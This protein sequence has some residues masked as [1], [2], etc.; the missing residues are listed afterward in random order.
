MPGCCITWFWTCSEGSDPLE[1]YA[2]H[3]VDYRPFGSILREY[4]PEVVPEKFLTTHHERDVQTGL[5]YRGSAFFFDSDLG[6]F[7]SVDPLA[8]K[9]ASISP[10]AYVA[11]NPINIH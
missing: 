7:L 9:Y 10:Y 5:D 1:Y 4:L 3:L 11:N 6:R 2:D 8:E